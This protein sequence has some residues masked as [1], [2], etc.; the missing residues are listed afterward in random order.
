ME[1]LDAPLQQV[2]YRLPSVPDRVPPVESVPHVSS[3]M[4]D[5]RVGGPARQ[6]AMKL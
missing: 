3:R 4:N 6:E 2:E 5:R 1:V